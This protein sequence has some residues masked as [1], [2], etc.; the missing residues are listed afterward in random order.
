[1]VPTPNEPKATLPG[2]W[3]T[4]AMNSGKVFACESGETASTTEEL[5]IGETGMKSATTSYGRFL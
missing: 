1:M 3:R 5:A 4:L 2:F